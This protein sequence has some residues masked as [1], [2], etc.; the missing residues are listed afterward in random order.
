M[1]AW[2][3]YESTS[4]C[5]DLS[6]GMVVGH[7]DPDSSVEYDLAIHNACGFD[8]NLTVYRVY[9]NWPTTLW[10]ETGTTPLPPTIF[11][12]QGDTVRFKVRVETP[13]GTEGESDIARV[14]IHVLEDDSLATFSILKTV[15]G[16]QVIVC[17]D[18]NGDLRITLSD[19]T[20]LI[21]HV[22]ISKQPL[23][24]PGAANVNGSVDG[25]ITLS[26][27]TLLISHLYIVEEVLL[28]P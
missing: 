18:V 12:P 23:P 21:D 6:P 13:T 27:I 10:D 25:L 16:S 14:E 1:S 20:R 15:I 22:Y 11:V 4:I 24:V 7:G 28:C 17:G 3:S 2:Y 9:Y 5:A 26:D 8:A 19:I